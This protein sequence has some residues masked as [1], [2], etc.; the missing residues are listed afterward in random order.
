MNENV[1]AAP[2]RGQIP[3]RPSQNVSC[4]LFHAEAQAV[5]LTSM[6]F[7]ILSVYD[8]PFQAVL[9]NTFVRTLPSVPGLVSVLGT[10]EASA[11]VLAFPVPRGDP[12][13]Y[14][15]SYPGN[16]HRAASLRLGKEDWAP[17]L[18]S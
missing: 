13:N 10:P 18:C 16:P 4:L 15:L 9:Q 7:L 3:G 17:I 11:S 1:P 12:G 14:G 2:G 8:S 5:P 6:S